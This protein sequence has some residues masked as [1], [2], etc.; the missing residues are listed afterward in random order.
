MLLEIEK[1]AKTA[2]RELLKVAKLEKGDVFV[3]GCSSS[4][5]TGKNLGTS[6]SIETAKAVFSGIYPELK[7]NGIYLASQCC[8]HLN[9][10]IITERAVA[11]EQR[12]QIVNAIPQIKA[13]GS[14]ATVT[15][16]N[17]ENPCAVETI[18]AQAGMD[19]GGVL[20]GMHLQQ[21]AV[22]VRISLDHIGEA[23]L[24]CAR[25]RAKFVGGVRAVYDDNLL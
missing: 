18:K 4:E 7:E 10:A 12:L 5:I 8:E 6:S 15:Y 14:F 1:Q 2:T 11:K 20:I 9:R 24:I 3:V 13:G 22:P 21:T 19:I 23:I 25:T 16:E 17:L